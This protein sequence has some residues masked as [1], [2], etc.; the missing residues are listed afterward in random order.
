MNRDSGVQFL[1]AR[2]RKRPR[3]DLSST[4]QAQSSSVATPRPT[5]PPLE[6]P[7]ARYAGDGL[8]YRRPVTASVSVLEEE[9]VIDLTNEPDSP[10][11]VRSHTFEGETASRRP[12]PPR[13]GRDIMA[14]DVVDLEE[15]QSLDPPSSPEV[16]FLSSTVR[17]QHPQPRPPPRAHGLMSSNFWRMLPLPQ[18]FSLRREVPWHAAAHLSRPE[19]DR[20]YIGDTTGTMDL[21]IDLGIEDWVTATAPETARPR[22][23]YK[24][25]SPAPEGFTRSVQE[26]DIAICPN[27]DEELGTGDDIKQ[28]IWVA[29]QCGHVYCGECATNRSLTKAKKTT[30]KTKPFAKCQVEDCGKPISAP[31]SMFQVYL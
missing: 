23:S 21:T 1:A 26:D 18:A 30:S 8:D 10:E 22:S 14:P 12:R 13:F 5:L 28:Q 9:D 29:K 11:I 16:Q 31:K 17:Q 25:P 2:R 27:C 19:I 24:A 15:E 3:R 20:L 4:P 6:L 7:A